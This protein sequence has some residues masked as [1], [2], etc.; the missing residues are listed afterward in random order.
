MA[1]H[2]TRVPQAARLRPSEGDDLRVGRRVVGGYGG[3]GQVL[4]DAAH[5]EVDGQTDS[6]RDNLSCVFAL[7]RRQRHGNTAAAAE[8]RPRSRCRR[9][10]RPVSTPPPSC[11]PRTKTGTDDEGE[12]VGD[13]CLLAE[14]HRRIPRGCWPGRTSQ[15]PCRT[16]RIPGTR[17]RPAGASQPEQR[18]SNVRSP[19][20]LKRRLS[21]TRKFPNQLR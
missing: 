17:R 19:P 10:V 8:N 20:A 6:S 18:C 9:P 16:G 13:R 3:A 2:G 11:R 5:D 1:V 12:E 14:S 4:K 21:V 7:I 15:A